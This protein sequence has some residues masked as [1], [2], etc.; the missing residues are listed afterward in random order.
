MP[1]YTPVHFLRVLP[2]NTP[3]RNLLI[4]IYI[5]ICSQAKI[6]GLY[7]SLL[8]SCLLTSMLAAKETYSKEKPKH[9]VLL[10]IVNNRH[11]HEMFVYLPIKSLLIKI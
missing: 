4:Y 9:S 10:C 6:V 11:V 3:P 2:E 8:N 7:P 5:Y 1:L